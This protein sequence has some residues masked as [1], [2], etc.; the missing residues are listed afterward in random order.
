MAIS[1]TMS[2]LQNKMKFICNDH[3]TARYNIK[4]KSEKKWMRVCPFLTKRNLNKQK[5]WIRISI[6]DAHNNKKH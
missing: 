2:S 5:K 1:K 6:M 4:I 3:E